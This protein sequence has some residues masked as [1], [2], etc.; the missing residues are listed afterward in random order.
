MVIGWVNWKFEIGLMVMGA[1]F[2][3]LLILG[4]LV[5]LGVKQETWLTVGMPY[6]FS[7][8]YTLSPDLV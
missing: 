4:S 1:L 8:G 2:F 3:L 7:L 5:L 6:L